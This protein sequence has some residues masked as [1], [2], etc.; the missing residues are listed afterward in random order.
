MWLFPSDTR[1]HVS[2]GPSTSWVA[3]NQISETNLNTNENHQI[4]ITLSSGM[5]SLYINGTLQESIATTNVESGTTRPLYMCTPTKTCGNVLIR[6]VSYLMLSPP[7]PPSS[8]SPPSPPPPGLPPG[9]PPAPPSPPP[10]PLQPPSPP[11]SYCPAGFTLN[12]GTVNDKCVSLVNG[13]LDWTNWTVPSGCQDS[14]DLVPAHSGGGFLNPAGADP[15]VLVAPCFQSAGHTSAW[16]GNVMQCQVQPVSADGSRH[17]STVLYNARTG[18]EMSLARILH[19]GCCGGNYVMFFMANASI[20]YNPNLIFDVG[21]TISIRNPTRP[22]PNT[23]M[24]GSATAC[25]VSLLQPPAAP[26]PPDRPPQPPTLPSPPTPPPTPPIPPM[27]PP[28]DTVLNPHEGMRTYSSVLNNHLSAYALSMLDS[29]N[30]WIP[31]W[32]YGPCV[33]ADGSACWMQIDL[34]AERHVAGV[35]TQNRGQA[36]HSGWKVNTFSVKAC[37]TGQTSLGGRACRQFEDVDNGASFLGPQANWA[38]PA[39]TPHNAHVHALFETFVVTRFIRIRPLTWSGGNPC[40]RAAVLVLT[41]PPTPPAPP[42]LPPAPAMPLLAIQAGSVTLPIAG[43]G[44]LHRLVKVRGAL[45]SL[46][47][48]HWPIPTARSYDGAA[49]E[50][51]YPASGELP[52]NVSQCSSSQCTLM[53]PPAAS[54]YLY[55]VDIVNTAGSGLSTLELRQRAAAKLLIQGTFG[56]TRDELNNLTT[57]LE[58]RTEEQLSAEWVA[59]QIATPPSLHRV[60]YRERAQPR[61]AITR[62]GR[63]ACEP[64]SRWLRYAFTIQDITVFEP[65]TSSQNYDGAPVSNITIS[66]QSGVGAV[67][68]NGL[69]RTHIRD[70]ST[71]DSTNALGVSEGNNWTG[72]VC[73]V[74]EGVRWIS[75]NSHGR[76][77]SGVDLSACGCKVSPT[78]RSSYWPPGCSASNFVRL[79]NPAV[80]LVGE[81]DPS[82]T[83]VASVSEADVQHLPWIGR[84]DHGSYGTTLGIN[85]NSATEADPVYDEV[86]IVTTMRA[87]CT[88]STVAQSIRGRGFLIYNGSAYVHDPRLALFDN[89]L[90]SGRDRHLQANL[91]SHAAN[92]NQCHNAPKSILNRDTCMPSTACAPLSYRAVGV[93]LNHST[94]RTFHEHTNAYIYAV[95]GLRIDNTVG[96]PCI[97]TSRWLLVSESACGNGETALDTATKATL[98]QAIRGS[99]DAINP[100]VRDAIANTVSGSCTSTYNGVSAIGARVDVDGSCW[101][102]SHPLSLNV[103]EMNQWAVNH[104]GNSYFGADA[105]PI[106]AFANR[107]ETTLQFPASHMMSR[108]TGAVSTFALLGKYADTVDFP[109]LPS[110]AKNAEVARVFDALIVGGASESCGSPGEVANVP[111]KGHHFHHDDR[112]RVIGWVK[113]TYHNLDKYYGHSAQIHLHLAMQAPDQL[114]QRAAHALIQI[115]VMSHEGADFLW[116]TEIWIAYYDILVRHAF[117]NSRNILLEISCTLLARSNSDA[118]LLPHATIT[119]MSVLRCADNPMMGRYL[120]Y[121]ASNSL[122]A[123]GTQPDQNYARE[124]MQLFSIGLIELQP[125]GSFHLNS[126]GEPVETYD[127]NDI[128]DFAK[129]WTAFDIR[130]R[131]QNVQNEGHSRGNR[132]DPMLLLANGA[133]SKRDLFPKMDL[134]DGYLGDGEPLCADL[135]PRHFLSRGAHWSFLGT[136]PE[137]VQQPE[138]IHSGTQ[139]K[140]NQMRRNGLY[141]DISMPRLQPDPSASSLYQQLCQ[142]TTTG[143][144]CEFVSELDL[145]A[146]LPCHGEECK[147]D[148]VSLV[149]ILDPVANVTVYYEYVRRPCTELTFF[150]GAIARGGSQRQPYGLRMCADPSTEVA[151][152]ACCP[153]TDQTDQTT[154]Q[155]DCVYHNEPMSYSTAVTRCAARTDGKTAVCAD[156]WSARGCFGTQSTPT[157]MTGME[158]ER[159]WM[160]YNASSTDCQPQ[161]Q[162]HADGRVTLI[163]TSSTDQ[164]LT[165]DS[166]NVFRVRWASGSYP[167]VDATGLCWPG[168]TVSGTSCVCDTQMHSRTVFTHAENLTAITV[169]AVEESLRIGSAPPDAFAADEY[170][171][172]SLAACQTARAR[173]VTIFTHSSSSDAL[174]E[175]SIFLV[176]RNGTR[177]TYLANKA[178]TVAVGD[179]GAF[180]FRNPPKFHSFLR[181]SV[182]DAEH[183]TT[184]LIDHLFWHQN[185]GPFLA[186]RLIQRFSSS[187]PSPRYVRAVAD[188][189]KAGAYAGRTYSGAY[190]DLGALFAAL[191]LDREARSSTLDADPT[192]GQLREPL[193]KAYHVLRSLEW[194]TNK[195]HLLEASTLHASIGQYHLRSPTVFNFYDPL[196][197]PVGPLAETR[198][199]APEAQLG[200]GPFV[201]GWLNDMTAALRGT[202]WNGDMRYTARNPANITEVVD[203]LDLLL[204]GGRLNSHSKGVVA[205]RYTEILQRSSSLTALRAAEEL[206]LFTP[207]F[208]STNM[209]TRR[210]VPRAIAPETPSQGRGYKAIVYLYLNGGADTYNLLVPMDGC[211]ARDLYAHY[212]SIRRTNAIPKSSLLPINVANGTQPCSQFGVHQSM[213][214]LHSLYNDGDAAFVAN[215]GPLIQPL[216]KTTLARGAPRPPSLYSHNT[217]TTCALNVHA[218]AVSSAKGV[219]GRIMAALEKTSPDGEPPYRQKSFSIAGTTKILEGSVQPPEILSYSVGPV[220]LTRYPNVQGDV[221]ELTSSESESIFAETFSQIIESSLEGAEALKRYLDDDDARLTTTFGTDH[222]SK[223]FQQAASVIAARRLTEHERDV[224]FIQMRGW[225]THFHLDDGVAP[226]WTTVNNALTSFVNEMKAQG[227][228]DNVTIAMGSEFGR[229]IDNNGGGTDHG[230]GGNVF[231]MGGAVLGGQI[232]GSFPADMSHAANIRTGRALIPTMSWEGM[233]NALALWFGVHTNDMATVLPSLNN[234]V[235]C[236]STGCGVISEGMMFKGAP[237]PSPPPASPPDSP[238]LPPLVPPPPPSPPVPPHPPPDP[239]LPTSDVYCPAAGYELAYDQSDGDKCVGS[240]TDNWTP[241]LGCQDS[242]NVVPELNGV[243]MEPRVLAESC[244]ESSS[245]SASSRRYVERCRVQ[246]V[247]SIRSGGCSA[248]CIFYNGRGQQIQ[249]ISVL[250]WGWGGRDVYL[251]PLTYAGR[252]NSIFNVGDTMYVR[253]LTKMRPGSVLPYSTVACDVRNLVRPPSTPPPPP[254]P[255]FG[256]SPPMPPPSPPS[257]PLPPSTPPPP[258]SVTF[259]GPGFYLNEGTVNDKCVSI[260]GSGSCTG[261]GC[262]DAGLDL[263]NWTV[264]LGCQDSIDLVPAHS[265]TTG[266]CPTGYINAPDADP[267]VLAAP[268]FYN[269]GHSDAWNGHVQQC[270]VQPVSGCVDPR[271][272]RTTLYNARTGAEMSVQRIV[273]WGS[274]CGG[275]YAFFLMGNQ[276]LAYTPNLIFEVGDTILLRRDTRP[277]PN[278]VMPGSATACRVSALRPPSAPSA[279]SG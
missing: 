187:N 98:A 232:L 122:A 267:R 21:D 195:G 88:L 70:M 261:T 22:S 151:A 183:E 111:S 167:S 120:T 163:H 62:Q 210:E 104:P 156:M 188:A 223:Q 265:G 231:V 117:G 130:P 12:A 20:H 125:D 152:A 124:V 246:P 74:M 227:V 169:G 90:E 39:A 278:T 53:L 159:S 110:T 71:W 106:K 197:Q 69:L 17:A 23:V 240:G 270:Q 113:E 11:V 273:Q 59:E 81:L 127:T 5:L 24:P 43:S 157:A 256:P 279:I 38:G 28:F 213:S 64:M 141:D 244:V 100:L 129:C 114:R 146:T 134:H 155:F 226:K 34:G 136:S 102:H 184:A 193:L 61:V 268:C 191:M 220:R 253:R 25:K 115:F 18:A 63:M 260:G 182:R 166:G 3:V 36:A 206:F 190:G 171:M 19:W 222:L 131:R 185:H 224:F 29:T 108:F 276:S 216:D 32:T 144:P 82:T 170:T 76:F 238:P 147:V 7:S 116:N 154:A 255:P 67:Y 174:D 175:R 205:A 176:L 6:R 198:L 99:T 1:L 229:T 13:L 148:T 42:A 207:E 92:L 247:T 118:N 109:N 31:D 259:C 217:Q 252:V 277:S 165:Q 269:T 52:V 30:A 168:C 189:F 47:T 181:P 215:I 219:L 85:G 192:H 241:P 245:H 150:H 208:H 50:A 221:S 78:G 138:A 94:L 236:S 149:S 77:G 139:S 272:A 248:G 160:K 204:T 49:W 14:I 16:N 51:L 72:Y 128:E 161:L 235:D 243:G 186:Y 214:T 250:H 201:I 228:W 140:M 84:S 199:V 48:G 164:S 209:N 132:Y 10:S 8:P 107:G 242:Q 9:S 212:A 123:S 66:T 40:L 251:S 158:D 97:G 211:P 133:T 46:A 56:P 202:K 68:V 264:P 89:S 33:E 60:F 119:D 178:A 177:P 95:A 180:T 145:S 26:P 86:M 101:E 80:E 41:T 194:G 172:C 103:Y 142:A 218:N 83:L 57:R 135:P 203:E 15:R 35:V 75:S 257:P 96:S 2:Y 27:A 237:G 73:R 55:R 266:T 93:H 112:G 153:P 225:D 45:T 274:C 230:W 262:P 263:T 271:H 91:R 143:A 87:P 79:Q 258:L 4:R 126:A 233:W 105:N 173:G 239:P 37:S 179:D 65:D 162:V 234:F 254:V 275:R 121:E 54:G 44:E 196:Y 249:I 58:T 200:T 137:A